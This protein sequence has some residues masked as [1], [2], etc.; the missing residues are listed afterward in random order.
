[1]TQIHTVTA[2]A[3]L[4]AALQQSYERAHAARKAGCAEGVTAAHDCTVHT[5]E[6][7]APGEPSTLRRVAQSSYGPFLVS[8]DADNAEDHTQTIEE[9]K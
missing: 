8:S 6:M 7:A 4:L 1:M 5:T 2:A 9:T 3:D